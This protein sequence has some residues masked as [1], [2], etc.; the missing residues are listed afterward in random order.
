MQKSYTTFM[1]NKCLKYIKMENYYF[2]AKDIYAIFY[3]LFIGVLA[4]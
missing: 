2:T 3:Y 1:K 4:D